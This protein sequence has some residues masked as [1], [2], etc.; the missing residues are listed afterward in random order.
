M[1]RNE[2]PSENRKQPGVPKG[3]DMGGVRDLERLRCRCR[4]DEDTGCWLWGM[5]VDGN[6]SRV[7]VAHGD[8]THTV[9]NG[10]RAALILAGVKFKPGEVGFAAAHCPSTNC[11]NPAHARKGTT[12]EA[13]RARAASGRAK[14]NLGVLIGAENSAQRSRKL[15]PEQVHEARTS[16]ESGASLSRRWG[17]SRSAISYARRGLTYRP[18]GFSVFSLPLA[19][20]DTEG[21]KAA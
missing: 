5:C 18:K 15:T 9:M 3:S 17:V 7:A 11:V 6:L 10:R 4:I 20:N 21:R 2:V 8:S 1:S 19:S 12:A 14:A 13:G 16:N